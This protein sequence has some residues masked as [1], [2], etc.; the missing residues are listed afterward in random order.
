MNFKQSK[1]EK[2]YFLLKNWWENIELTNFEKNCLN[3]DI[4]SFNQ[5]LFRLKHKIIRVGVYG[6]ASVGKSSILN[7]ILN[8]NF[9]KTDIINGS[10]KE[11]QLKTLS[12]EKGLV[13]TIELIDFPGFDIDAITNTKKNNET[14]ISL[15]LIIF[16]VS[17]DLNRGELSEINYLINNGKKIIIV[18]NKIDIW[19]N[20]ELNTILKNIK[21]KL[22]K[23][24]I[25]PIVINSNKKCNF[26]RINETLKD[27]LIKTIHRFGHSI[28]IYNTL[29]IA[30]KLSIIIK[31]K[32]LSKRKR[33]AQKII[34]KFATLKASSVALNPLLFL[35]MASSFALDT[36]LVHELSKVYGLKI[37]RN[38]VKKLIKTISVNNISLGAAQICVN[39]L[40]SLVR[41]ISLLSAP[42]TNG[43]SLVPYGPIALTQAALAVGSTKLV[44]K[45]AA[46]EILNKSNLCAIEPYH[47]IQQ[48]DL[49]EIQMA[50]P[51][52]IFLYNQ[53]KNKDLSLFIP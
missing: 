14:L 8:E 53:K 3:K 28:I 11:T 40:F 19:N 31:E 47:L 6:K 9:F 45:L 29:Q 16:V 18:L 41:K 24:I 20:D 21:Y 32:R 35:D 33:E 52:R 36:A 44:G 2:S 43:L 13:K 50:G 34:G 4:I 25:I 46:K 10:T 42:F 12:F 5:Q 51:F 37:K 17:G 30:S 15:D 39:T 27:Y 48:I 26:I 23:N 1:I 38:S 22:P 7:T 49:K